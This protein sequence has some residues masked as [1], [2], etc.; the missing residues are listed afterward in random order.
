M[1]LKQF[2]MALTAL[3]AVVFFPLLAHAHPLDGTWQS[4]FMSD[5]EIVAD[6]NVG[7]FKLYGK[8][9]TLEK[10][11]ELYNSRYGQAWK[12][13]LVDK[14]ENTRTEMVFELFDNVLL[15]VDDACFLKNGYALPGTKPTGQWI[16]EWKTDEY[17]AVEIYDLD[18]YK[19]EYY[20]QYDPDLP[21]KKISVEEL[22]HFPTSANA[23]A[24]H[25]G[26]EGYAHSYRALV[27]ITDNFVLKVLPDELLK[28]LNLE[29]HE[30]PNAMVLRRLNM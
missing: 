14:D 7:E 2:P 29:P 21:F 10:I 5:D 3:V 20:K 18:S 4:R 22:F 15:R 12:L 6:L 11:E 19:L 1:H 9:F 16:E 27:K 25:I 30:M 26:A 23:V 13:E 24:F 17:T 28:V 8:R